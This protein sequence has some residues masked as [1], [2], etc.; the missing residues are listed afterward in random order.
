[1]NVLDHIMGIEEASKR[2]RLPRQDIV[3][4]CAE[5]QVLAVRL[6]GEDVWV[7][8][9]DQPNPVTG[10]APARQS[11]PGTDKASYMSTKLLDAL[12]E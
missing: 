6:E 1:M 12:Y 10:D 2:W 4:L 7:L 3:R 11:R 9:K 5:G 8:V